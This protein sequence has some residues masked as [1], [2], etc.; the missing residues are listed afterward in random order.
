[1][2]RFASQRAINH[3]DV[4]KIKRGPTGPQ[5]PSSVN[6]TTGPTGPQGSQGSTGPMGVTG[7]QGSQGSTGPTG[8][9]L[10]N[11]NGIKGQLLTIMGESNEA[12][13][14]GQYMFSYGDSQSSFRT[15]GI[16]I[17]FNFKLKRFCLQINNGDNLTDI[18]SNALVVL[19]ARLLNVP[20]EVYAYCDFSNTTNGSVSNKI[21]SNKFSS[22][23]YSQI[24]IEP[25]F[26]SSTFGTQISFLVV[27]ISNIDS[28]FYANRFTVVIETTE[29][30]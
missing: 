24:D 13:Q 3:T 23:Q 9:T 25:E 27:K 26:T 6:G 1:M 4:I 2:Y 11:L 29:D 28:T 22:S 21:F 15:F 10:T 12:L 30:L 14:L 17:P 7:P 20:Q 5:G 19:R 18:P 8:P 16:G